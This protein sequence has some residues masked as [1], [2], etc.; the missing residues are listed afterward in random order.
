MS[1]PMYTHGPPVAGAEV[2]DDVLADLLERVGAVS[3]E[4]A[5]DLFV[6]RE[7]ADEVVR[8]RGDRIVT[9]EPRVKRFLRRRLVVRERREREER[10]Q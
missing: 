5:C 9:A 2:V 6:R 4:V 7:T 1:R 8:H 3:H 10:D